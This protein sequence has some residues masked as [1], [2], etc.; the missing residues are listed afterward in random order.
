VTRDQ[1]ASRIGGIGALLGMAAGAAVAARGNDLADGNGGK[2]D[3]TPL[4]LLTVALSVCAAA[5]CLNQ[6]RTGETGIGPG[7]R[8]AVAGGQLVPALI[9]FT[10]VGRLWWGPG[11]LLL[12]AAGLTISSA[13]AAVARAVRGRWPAVLLGFLAALV[14]LVAS[15]ASLA[16]LALAV[17]GGALVAASSWVRPR[18][19]R[20]AAAMV[21]LGVL[22]FAVLTWWSLVTPVLAV[23]ML[24]AGWADGRTADDGGGAPGRPRAAAA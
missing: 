2:Q 6:A 14:V 19:P 15:T 5:A 13:P 23:L 21:L 16:L 9:C 4:G 22:P 7:R 18:R 3:P 20:W 8:A 12:T 24:V 10:T 11:V 17:A 1:F